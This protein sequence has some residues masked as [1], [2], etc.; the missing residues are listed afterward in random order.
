[1]MTAVYLIPRVLE[2]SKI[3]HTALFFG[4]DFDFD[5]WFYGGLYRPIR[6]WHESIVD[7]RLAFLRLRIDWGKSAHETEN[8]NRN[9]GAV[10]E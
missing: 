5:F 3:L 10:G 9:M 6:R 4:F 2:S 7:C 8:R 1:M